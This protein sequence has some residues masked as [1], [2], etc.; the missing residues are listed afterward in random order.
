MVQFVRLVLISFCW[1]FNSYSSCT[2][3]EAG[4]AIYLMF[5]HHN[6]S[7]DKK[8]QCTVFVAFFSLESCNLSS[9]ET[10]DQLQPSMEDKNSFTGFYNYDLFQI[11]WQF[12]VPTNARIRNRVIN[13][14]SAILYGSGTLNQNRIRNTRKSP[15]IKFATELDQES[16]H[17]DSVR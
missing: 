12:S 10:T 9:F 11:V 1:V 2:H 17:W 8:Q 14:D 6:S 16:I 13:S 4:R 3:V 5:N 7:W 15:I